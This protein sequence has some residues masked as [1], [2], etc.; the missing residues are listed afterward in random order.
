M[1]ENEIDGTCGTQG[2]GKK[3]YRVL[4]G[5]PERKRPFEGPRHRWRLGLDGILCRFA[6][7]EVYIRGCD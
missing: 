2:R 6:V 1:K 4:V 3:V 5:K 7:S